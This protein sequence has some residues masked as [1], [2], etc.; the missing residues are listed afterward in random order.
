MITPLSDTIVLAITK[1]DFEHD[2]DQHQGPIEGYLKGSSQGIKIHPNETI[3]DIH[4]FEY[5]M[6]TL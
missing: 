1:R 3:I 2:V 4:D 6:G 5:Y